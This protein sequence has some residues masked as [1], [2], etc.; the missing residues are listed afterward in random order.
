L[1]QEHLSACAQSTFPR[2]IHEPIHNP[3]ALNH[4]MAPG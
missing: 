1:W 4:K 3:C 2:R